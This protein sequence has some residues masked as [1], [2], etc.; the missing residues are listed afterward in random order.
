VEDEKH[1]MTDLDRKRA[2]R[3]AYEDRFTAVHGMTRGA[4]RWDAD[5]GYRT[6]EAIR[7]DANLRLR[8]AGITRAEL[9]AIFGPRNPN[10]NARN[11]SA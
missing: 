8:R 1:G 10:S 11:D 3:C 6:R 2:H 5:A 9:L 7:N 4:R